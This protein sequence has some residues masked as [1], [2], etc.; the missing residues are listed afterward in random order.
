MTGNTMLKDAVKMFLYDEK[1]KEPG[2]PTETN[3]LYGKP[4][5]TVDNWLE[6]AMAS[7]KGLQLF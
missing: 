1:T 4:E 2:D 7:K 3:K 5:I 6:E